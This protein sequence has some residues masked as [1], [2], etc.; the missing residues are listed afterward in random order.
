VSTAEAIA[1]I[2][3]IAGLVFLGA[4]VMLARRALSDNA[5]AQE[6]EWERQRRKSTLDMLAA[7]SQY[8]E[9]LKAGLPWND[10]DPKEVA[11]FLARANGDR[12]KLVPVREFLNY[13]E[14]LAVGARQG[15]FDIETISM[16]EGSR[17]IATAENYRVYV[18]DIRREIGKSTLYENLECL[19]E[20]L[21]SL[22]KSPIAASCDVV[23]KTSTGRSRLALKLDT[24]RLWMNLGWLRPGSA[25]ATAEVGRSTMPGVNAN[26]KPA[27]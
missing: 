14:D 18:E 7:T 24:K 15:V 13:Y 23:P 17:I 11:A 3:N 12:E 2:I 22:R 19:A 21:R 1:T 25:R 26:S 20:I 5:K 4:Q 6:R 9:S 8:R 16:S 10:R 27:R